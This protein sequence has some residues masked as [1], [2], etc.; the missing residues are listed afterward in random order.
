MLPQC[1]SFSQSIVGLGALSSLGHDVEAHFDAISTGRTG[2][3]A[4]GGLLGNDSLHA[5]RP[6]AWISPR[7]LLTNRKWSPASM[8]ALHVAREAVAA[9]G[10]GKDEL[11]D[12]ALIV[13]TSR[14]NAAGWLSPWPGRRPFRL[15]AASN[16]IHSEP[17]TAVS[18]E[19]GILGPNHVVASGCSAGLDALG[20]AKLLLDSRQAKRALV[21]AVDLPLVPVLLDNYASSGLLAESSPLN[22]F[23]SGACG[24][25]PAEGAA[26]IALSS[27]QQGDIELLHFSNNSDG[28]D[29]V[30]IPQGGG[31]TSELLDGAIRLTGSP[32]AICPHATGTKIQARAERAFLGALPGDKPTLHLLKPYFGHTVGASGL[33][34]STVL[35]RFMQDSRLP[36]NLPGTLGAG[37]MEAPAEAIACSGNVFKL[38]HGMG[39]HNALAVFRQT[40]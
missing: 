16:T 23:S 14:G 12:T 8:A 4:L 32:A 20:L 15:M 9:S 29:P 24:F 13:G 17:S 18:I 11:R 40:T 38:A 7:E 1:I 3:H 30:G 2:I 10:W 19:L 37:G 6:G 25:I 21:V 26:A 5:A 22:P 36:P 27:G 39:G 35:L 31:R 33:L 34:E 28:A